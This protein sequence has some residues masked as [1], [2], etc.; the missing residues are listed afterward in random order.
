MRMSTI[1][2]IQ[3]LKPGRGHGRRK[4]VKRQEIQGVSLVSRDATKA[5]TGEK[6]DGRDGVQQVVYGGKSITLDGARSEAFWDAIRR[7]LGETNPDPA[8]FRLQRDIQRWL[9]AP[10]QARWNRKR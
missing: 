3:P 6:E 4:G 1:R 8:T 5:E 2:Y 10:L 9:N 7:I